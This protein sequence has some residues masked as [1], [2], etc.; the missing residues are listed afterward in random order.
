MKSRFARLRRRVTYANV[1]ST[2]ALVIALGMGSAYAANQLAPKS[3]GAKQLRPGAVTADKIRKNAVIAPKIEALAVKQGKL[4]NGAVV[5]SKLAAGS[6]QADKLANGSV[7]PGKIPADSVTGDKINEATLGTVSSASSAD[8][9]SRAASANPEAFAKIDAEGT[10]D[11]AASKGIGTADV[12]NGPFPGVYC[13]NVPAFVPR[14]AQVTPEFVGNAQVSIQVKVGG[15][16]ACPY[17]QL[18]VQS[19]NAGSRQKQPFFLIAYR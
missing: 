9:A 12:L 3:V 18:E 17:P 5:A 10:V 19:Y 15:T 16:A 4:A 1:T 11:V 6:V 2:L 8:F 14:G 13:V 7:T